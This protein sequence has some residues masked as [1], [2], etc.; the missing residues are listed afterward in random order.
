MHALERMAPRWNL[1]FLVLLA[2]CAGS[3][4]DPAAPAAWT[5]Q[6]KCENIC[7]SY[8]VHKSGCDGSSIPACR[9]AIDHADGGT[10]VVRARLFRDIAE[11]QVQECID[12]VDAM[13]CPAF[14]DMYDTGANV[15]APCAGILS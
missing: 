7:Q 13:S 2:G 6:E 5:D 15:P 10:C 1:A 4:P 12:A 9:M 8:C 11:E 3:S 14:L